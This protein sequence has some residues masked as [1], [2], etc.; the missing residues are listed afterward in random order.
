[1][2]LPQV[3]LISVPSQK[4]KFR[5]TMVM[6]G[7]FMDVQG[8]GGRPKKIDGQVSFKFSVWKTTHL[9]MLE[10]VTQQVKVA[11]WPLQPKTG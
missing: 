1:M 7:C 5:G 6:N 10:E 11:R 8:L 4:K 3:E 9:E 2:D